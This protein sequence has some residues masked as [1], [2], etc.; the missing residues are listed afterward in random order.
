MINS[1]AMSANCIRTK[2]GKHGRVIVPAA[3]LNNLRLN[4]GDDII[5]HLDN[6]TVYISTPNYALSRLQQLVKDK[7]T[8]EISLVDDL[9]ESR[10]NDVRN[11]Q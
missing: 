6:N 4:A 3:F 7:N 10:K 9:L 8:E 11:E 2:L 5:V 1:C